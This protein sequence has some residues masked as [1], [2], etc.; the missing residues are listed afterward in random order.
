MVVM[1]LFNL[2]MYMVNHETMKPIN[3][4]GASVA[5][6]GWITLI[7]VSRHTD[8]FVYL[9]PVYRLSISVMFIWHIYNQD[10]LSNEC[11]YKS[12]SSTLHHELYLG[13]TF[14]VDILFISPSLN[15]TLL[16]FGTIYVAT[17][18]MHAKIIIEPGDSPSFIMKGSFATMQFLLVF[19]IYYFVNIQRLMH[20][21]ES[22][23]TS[24][25]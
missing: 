15:V 10:R 20:F 23:S 14:M 3:L 6:A 21:F 2:I 16:A 9:T 12:I 19:F 7:L 18:F 17:H 25:K 4:I 5:V 1:W 22:Y 24:T 8:N 13:V 11:D